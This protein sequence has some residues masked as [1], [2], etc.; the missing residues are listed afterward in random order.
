MGLAIVKKLVDGYG[1]RI[2]LADG[3]DGRGLSVRFTWPRNIK[4]GLGT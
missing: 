1:G 3:R 2:R 4:A